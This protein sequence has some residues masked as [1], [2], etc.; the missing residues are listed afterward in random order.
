MRVVLAGREYLYAGNAIVPG[1]ADRFCSSLGS[2]SHTWFSDLTMAPIHI[3]RVGMTKTVSLGRSVVEL[4]RPPA[5]ATAYRGPMGHGPSL[6]AFFRWRSP[7]CAGKKATSSA[8]TV[9]SY[10]RRHPTLP[11]PTHL[12]HLSVHPVRVFNLQ[13]R[14]WI[15]W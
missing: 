9:R 4:H 1:P 7:L 11:L 5:W 10:P 12:I 14:T 8:D 6:T 15:V 13:K 3:C 2:R